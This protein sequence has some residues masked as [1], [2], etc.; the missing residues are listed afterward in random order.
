VFE[1]VVDVVD[2]VLG[3]LASRI[4]DPG[5]TVAAAE[6]G[7]QQLSFARLFRQPFSGATMTVE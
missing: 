6:I 1:D 2:F 3:D 7:L 4:T 5:A